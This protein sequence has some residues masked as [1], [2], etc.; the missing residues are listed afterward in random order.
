LIPPT[1]VYH[2]LGEVN[3][4]KTQ[5]LVVLALA[6]ALTGCGSPSGDAAPTQA[7]GPPSSEAAISA[8]QAAPSSA[9]S[10]WHQY[11]NPQLAFSLQYPSDW[12]VAD[13][14]DQN[15]GALH[16]VEIAGPEGGLV[17]QWGTGMGGACPQGYQPVAV[18]QGTWPAC[19]SQKSD[20][21]DLWSLSGRT[22]GDAAL[23]GFAYTSDTTPSSRDLVLQVISTLSLP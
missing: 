21:T 16:Q 18:A 5:S 4:M 11:T 3:P 9:Q 8:S 7:I 19:H 2:D 12:H 10:T 15:N 17:L 6:L 1:P 22:I 20:G 23:A 13:L 14:P